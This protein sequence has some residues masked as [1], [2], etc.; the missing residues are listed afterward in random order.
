MSHSPHRNRHLQKKAVRQAQHLDYESDEK[1]PTDKQ[2]HKACT[3]P[4]VAKENREKAKSHQKEGH[5]TT[6]KETT[7]QTEPES[8]HQEG[9]RWKEVVQ[10]QDTDRTQRIDHKMQK[11]RNK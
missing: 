5:I 8:I 11:H 10:K 1:V 3:S 6:P 7:F 4:K 9:R 2:I